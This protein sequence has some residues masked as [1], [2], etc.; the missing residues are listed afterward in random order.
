MILAKVHQSHSPSSSFYLKFHSNVEIY[1]SRQAWPLWCQLFIYLFGLRSRTCSAFLF[2]IS[3]CPHRYASWKHPQIGT[4]DPT[5][6]YSSEVLA[7]LV[8]SRVSWLASSSH[9]NSWYWY[10]QPC[11]LY[12]ACYHCHPI[13][14][15]LHSH[16]RLQHLF[17]NHL[18]HRRPRP[19]LRW[20][21]YSWHLWHLVCKMGPVSC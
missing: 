5:G 18:P 6:C 14:L 12:L 2:I 8:L 20:F 4:V 21:T 17:Q 16:W 7:Y 3:W 1:H 13:R 15:H 11:W 10:W 19:S 9:L